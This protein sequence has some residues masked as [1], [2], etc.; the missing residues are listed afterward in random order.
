MNTRGYPGANIPAENI[1]DRRLKNV[2]AEQGAKFCCEVGKVVSCVHHVCCSFEKQT[3]V[4]LHSDKYPFPD[5][6]NDF[7]AVLEVLDQEKVFAPTS[8]RQHKIK[9]GILTD[10]KIKAYVQFA[11]AN[12]SCKNF[13]CFLRK[14]YLCFLC[15]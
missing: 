6:G 13:F 4:G 11:D 15:M 1:T 9:C 3:N 7:S 8:S 10:L 5:F 12:F 14:I 2:T